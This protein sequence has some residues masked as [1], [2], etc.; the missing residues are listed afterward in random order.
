[1]YLRLRREQ[2]GEDATE[3]ERLLDQLGPDPVIAGGRRVALV[4]DEV[5]RLEHGGEAVGELVALG[6][7]EGHA[8]LRQCALRAHDP[9]RDRRLRDQV[10]AGDLPGRQAGEQAQ[11]ERDPRVG[12]EHG[13]AGREDEAQEIVVERIVDLGLEIG[14]LDLAVDLDLAPQFPR[15]SL[16]D[17]GSA[18]AIDRPVLGR[19]HEP[20]ARVVR[21]ARLRPLLESGNER[22]LRQVLGDTD[23]AHDPRQA[24]DQTRR[25]DP[26]N[27]IDRTVD[28]ARRHADRRRRAGYWLASTCARSRA[29][30]SRNSGVNS[31]P[32]SSASKTGRISTTP[33]CPV[34]FG[35]RLTHSIASSRDFTC[36]TQ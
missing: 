32:K 11:G 35:M 19:A 34:G 25:L 18:Q 24:G 30:C 8:R 12:R 28:I 20:G 1:M 3:P 22:L 21:D 7:L 15:L 27:G 17:L 5:D 31:S 13:V 4:E 26:P 2:L 16:V 23:V 14:V 36:H 9:L 29:S 10:G 33:S 6:D